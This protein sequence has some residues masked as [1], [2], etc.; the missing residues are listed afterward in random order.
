VPANGL[1][2]LVGPSGCGKSTILNAIAGLVPYTGDV[3]VSSRRIGFAFQDDRLIPWRTV[4]QNMLF[5][6]NDC[7]GADRAME[8]ADGWLERLGLTAAADAFP[9]ALSGGMRRR[10]NLARALAVQPDILLLDEPF[11]FLDVA[12]VERVQAAVLEVGRDSGATTLIVS[13]VLE[14]VRGLSADVYRVCGSPISSV[15]AV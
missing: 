6:L 3:R 14:H 2:C 11:A 10:V 9:A 1:V 8:A 4:R 15:T 12:M 13:H 5:A 7:L